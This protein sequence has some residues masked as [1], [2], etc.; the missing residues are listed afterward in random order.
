MGK[1]WMNKPRQRSQAKPG[2]LAKSDTFAKP[3]NFTKSGTTAKPHELAK[4]GFWKKFFSFFRIGQWKTTIERKSRIVRSGREEKERTEEWEEEIPTTPDPWSRELEKA[5]IKFRNFHLTKSM[6]LGGEIQKKDYKIKKTTEKLY[7]LEGK[8]FQIILSTGNSLLHK[9]GK[10]TGLLNV[11][12][13]DINRA[14]QREHSSLESFLDLWNPTIES[15]DSEYGINPGTNSNSGSQKRDWTRIL[16]WKIFPGEQL[17]L[18]LRPDTIAL[19][20]VSLSEE[21][22]QFFL[23]RATQKQKKIVHDELFYLNQGKNSTDWNPHTKNKSILE[24]D[25]AVQELYRAIQ[26]VENR[27]ESEEIRENN[28]QGS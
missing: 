21:F 3:I 24:P 6:K 19:L 11:T 17:L 5:R 15:L 23:N 10:T 26:W 20:L 13:A 12:E 14:L 25:L 7:R 1:T 27:E 2:N 4:P 8:D 16:D 28:E 18:R 22:E 9:D